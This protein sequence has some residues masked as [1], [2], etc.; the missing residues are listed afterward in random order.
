MRL[1]WVPEQGR[2]DRGS[3]ICTGNYWFCSLCLPSQLASQYLSLPY[4]LVYPLFVPQ[5]RTLNHVPIH[6]VT[7]PFTINIH[8]LSISIFHFACIFPS[9]IIIW[10]P[11]A[12]PCPLVKTT[13]ELYLVLSPR[14]QKSLVSLTFDL[15]YSKVS[16]SLSGEGLQRST[17]TDEKTVYLGRSLHVTEGITLLSV[18]S[19]GFAMTVDSGILSS[20]P[21]LYYY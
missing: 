17:F 4:S 16:M 20:I 15:C 2:L 9:S 6:M 5:L 14:S 19:W 8:V 7:F 12:L 13:L 1:G 10:I 18:V 21:F 3:K 11:C